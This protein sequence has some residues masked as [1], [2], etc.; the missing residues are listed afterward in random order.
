MSADRGAR[1]LLVRLIEVTEQIAENTVADE[2]LREELR[3]LRQ[4][5]IRLWDV[6]DKEGR[7]A[8]TGPRRHPAQRRTREI[9]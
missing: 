3:E 8:D 4:R 1:A 7:G 2:D 9:P 6:A 5:G